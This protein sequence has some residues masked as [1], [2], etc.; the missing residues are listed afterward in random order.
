MIRVKYNDIQRIF[1]VA[2]LNAKHRM[3]YILRSIGD[4]AYGNDMTAMT[5]GMQ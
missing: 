5:N 2:L 1:D 4:N 3:K